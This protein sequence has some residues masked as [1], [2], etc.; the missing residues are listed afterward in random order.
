MKKRCLALVLALLMVLSFFGGCSSS[1]EQNS[2]GN[3]NDPSTSSNPAETQTLSVD[4]SSSTAT[5]TLETTEPSTEPF[6]EP[7]EEPDASSLAESTPEVTAPEPTA[8]ESP[9]GLNET[10]LNSIRMLNYLTVLSQEINSSS[11]SRIFLESA[12]SSLIN[13]TYPNAVDVRTE[14]HMEDLLDTLESFRMLTVKRERLEYIYE[15][16]RA[17]ALKAA[18]PN[19][20]GLL[21]AVRS[22]Q[23][24]KS[25]ISVIYMAVDSYTSYTAYTADTDLQYLQDGWDLDDAAAKEVHNTRTKTFSY[26]LDMVRSNDLPGDYA[27]NEDAVSEFVSWKNNSNVSRRIRFFE[28]NQETY[29]AFG[30]YWLALAESY[31]ENDDYERCLDAVHRYEEINAR[32]FR[33]DYGY[34]KVLPLA[35]VSARE[36][37][38]GE[39]YIATA[40]EYLPVILKNTD[41]SDWAICY[42]VAQTYV[43]LYAKTTDAAY[44][45][46]AY[47]LMIDV[48]NKLIDEQRQL[49]NTYL[50]DIEKEEIPKDAEKDEKKEIEQYNKMLV[51]TRKTELPPVSEPLRICSEMMFALADELHV[52]DSAKS[53][54]EKMLHEDGQDLFLNQL[55]DAGVRFYADSSDTDVA[56]MAVD[57]D[58]KQIKLP[59][60][61]MSSCSRIVTTVSD[62]NNESIIDDWTIKEVNRKDDNLESFVAVYESKTAKKYDY[63]ADMAVSIEI[64]AA[65]ENAVP[66][67]VI[68]YA[69]VGKKTLLV[70][71][72]ITFVRIA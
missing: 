62:G 69:V 8:V 6:T 14:A 50:A 47:N 19:P 51:E 35:I 26:M 16:N 21:S 10:Q 25:A 39:E 24:L 13:N 12:Y 18:I 4:A 46:D 36:I 54:I 29:Q 28:S 68:E 30:E 33:K 17:Q 40:A 67:A 49:N 53:K 58:G 1:T 59:A 31:Y 2:E 45:E 55:I 20:M 43:D 48:V 38:G 11:N 65:A 60:A 61:L 44:L 34:A 42:F 63:K 72:T 71:D 64:Y 52:P 15:Q 56:D 27:L 7:S 5:E 57:F 32:I 37:Y 66:D 41:I 70:F 3:T 22:D 23:P 9:S